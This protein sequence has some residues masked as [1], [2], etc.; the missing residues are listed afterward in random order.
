M[1]SCEIVSQLSL[2]QCS[3]D[4]TFGMEFPSQRMPNPT[5]RTPTTRQYFLIDVVRACGGEIAWASA[6]KI[7]V[8]HTQ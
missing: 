6:I 7:N 2:Q 1:E 3:R 8:K 4:P 5:W